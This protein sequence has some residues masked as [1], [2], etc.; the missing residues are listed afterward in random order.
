MVNRKTLE[1]QLVELVA[2]MGHYGV[3]QKL[4]NEQER[5][6]MANVYMWRRDAREVDGYLDEC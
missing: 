6:V 2:D 5:L 1:A 4:T 3:L